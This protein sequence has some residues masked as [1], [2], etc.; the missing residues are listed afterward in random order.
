MYSKEKK[1]TALKTFHQTKSVSEMMR[2]LGYPT[3][4][5]LF[6]AIEEYTIGGPAG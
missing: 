6:I 2:I 3:R 4:S 1:E 5:Q